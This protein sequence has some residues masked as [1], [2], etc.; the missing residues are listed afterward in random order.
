MWAVGYW[1]TAESLLSNHGPLR[2]LLAIAWH[3]CCAVLPC[4]AQSAQCSQQRSFSELRGDSLLWATGSRLQGLQPAN[5]PSRHHTP[6]ASRLLPQGPCGVR[7]IPPPRIL[8]PVPSPSLPTPSLQTPCLPRPAS[9]HLAS[10]APCSPA[11]CSLA[12]LNAQQANPMPRSAIGRSLS[13]RYPIA[14]I[15]RPA[16][17]EAGDRRTRAWDPRAVC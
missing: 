16:R 9:R 3:P 13:D 6:Q 7:Y 11:L 5:R 14:G 4:R 2:S 15:R 10:Q 17:P 12:A 1:L 8:R